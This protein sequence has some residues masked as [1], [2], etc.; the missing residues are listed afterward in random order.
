MLPPNDDAKPQRWDVKWEIVAMEHLLEFINGNFFWLFLFSFVWVSCWFG[1]FYYKH[2]KTG[3][4]FPPVPDTGVHYVEG[5]ASG[6]SHKT[7]F[8]R[9]GG[10][11]RC[12][13][14]TVTDTEVWIRPY[15]PFDIFAQM[16][17]MEHRIPRA[18]ITSVRPG[19][20]LWV[21]TLILDYQD[22]AGQMHRVSL[23]L[24]NPDAFLRALGVGPGLPPKLH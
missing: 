2:K 12:L 8:T 14:V 24:R 18:S 20:T 17:D 23:V 16:F 5:N 21:R 10:A 22:Q 1:W 6:S 9:L 11:S 3:I 7:L 4:V 15:P 13:R 19:K